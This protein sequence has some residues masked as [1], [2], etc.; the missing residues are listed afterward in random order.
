MGPLGFRLLND[1]RTPSMNTLLLKLTY[2]TRSNVGSALRE[3]G[4]RVDEVST[5]QDVLR[6]LTCQRYD[7]LLLDVQRWDED[8]LGTVRRVRLSGQACAVLLVCDPRSAEERVASLEAGCDDV[9]ERGYAFDELVARIRAQ[10]RRRGGYGSE[11]L[12]NGSIRLYQQRRRV[13]A[14][15]SEIDLTPKEFSVLAHLLSRCGEVVSRTELL[16]TVWGHDHQGG[17]NIV[18]VYVRRLRAKLAQAAA[19]LDTVRGVGYRLT[20]SEGAEVLHSANQVTPSRNRKLAA[21][22]LSTCQKS[23]AGVTLM[24]ERLS[25]PGEV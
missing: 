17:S 22:C 16:Q 21:S 24:T 9:I 10:V 20:H 25:A 19:Q 13:Y 15:G 6:N 12:S 8:V 3:M 18:D 5:T 4:Y 14:N 23:V 7:M 2:G 1:H 11:L